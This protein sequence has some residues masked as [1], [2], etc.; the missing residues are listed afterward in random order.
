MNILV[1]TMGTTWQI[2]PELLG[3]S[4]PELGY[5][6]NHQEKDAIEEMRQSFDIEAVRR[7]YV[8]TTGGVMTGRAI[9][10]LERWAKECVEIDIR[11]YRLNDV[12]ELS[13]EEECRQMGDYIYRVVLH[14]SQESGRLYLSLAGGRKTMSA[15]MQQAGNVFGCDAMLHVV[16]K[17]MPREIRER[18]TQLSFCEVIPTELI[19]YVM[20]IVT[21]GKTQADPLLWIETP[22]K[23]ED[24]PVQREGRGSTRL[25][26]EVH[27]WQVS[28]RNTMINFTMQ[29]LSATQTS[30]F[31][32]LY[33]LPPH[34]IERLKERTADY[35]FVK[36]LP[37]AELHCHFGGIALPEEMVE[38][39]LANREAISRYKTHNI[40]YATFLDEV[41]EAIGEEDIS[42][43]QNLVPD[44][45]ALRRRFETVPEPYSVAGFLSCFSG[46]AKL[47]KQFIYGDTHFRR[48]GIEQY[49]KFGDLQGSGLLQS[50][51]S[52]RSACQ[53]LARKAAEHRVT[54]LEVRCSPVNYARGSLSAKQVVEIMT[55]MFNAEKRT[56]FKLLF[57]ASRH[58]KM[59]D[60]YEHIE[61]AQD[62]LATHEG[63]KDYF[64]GFDLAGAEQKRAPG[65]LREAFMP[66][67]RECIPIT[68]HA[69]ETVDVTSIWEAVYH[70]SADRIGHGLTLGQKPQ[71]M[72][73]FKERKIAI[74]MCP[75]S[76]DQI[77]GFDKDYPLKSYLQYGLHVTINTDNPGISLTDFTQEYMKA[78]E[79]SPEPLSCWEVLILVRN[80]FRAAFLSYEQKRQHILTAEQEIVKWLLE[81]WEGR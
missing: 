46:K 54:Y 80:A 28:S 48:V 66:L 47:L 1:V 67:M 77:V 27:R 53:I 39:A 19:S 21:F 9:E 31:L 3:F 12:E 15:E 11:I 23:T 50:E 32:A 13:S 74:E 16:D 17:A 2:V 52:I 44:V 8:I 26:D 30:N 29:L 33:T 22:I 81:N 20:P 5:Y 72:E 79:L 65:E 71:L 25:Y 14:A 51:A 69:G 6:E 36:A 18:F 37:K 57:I 55:E 40:A 34:L 76:N 64:A 41:E 59:S 68:I 56:H 43:L 73:R 75:S 10:A 78:S 60:V 38:I 70:L 4:N 63:F 45:K 58:G 35:D 49:E 62:M 24:Y 42:R 7:V 61:L